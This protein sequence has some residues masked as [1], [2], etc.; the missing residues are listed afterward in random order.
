MFKL[1]I[2]TRVILQKKIK[3]KITEKIK[4][5]FKDNLAKAMRENLLRRKARII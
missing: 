4:K 2:L 5:P 1:L 3:R